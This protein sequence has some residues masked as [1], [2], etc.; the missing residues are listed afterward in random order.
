M[1]V[2]KKIKYQI[3]EMMDSIDTK[4]MGA[5]RFVFEY[6]NRYVKWFRTATKLLTWPSVESIVRARR[7]VTAE[8]PWKYDR[9]NADDQ[10]VYIQEYA[11]ECT[12]SNS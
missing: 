3:R 12:P 4:D 1:E 2:M 10:S 5:N 6:L 9:T 11:S 7:K 8:N